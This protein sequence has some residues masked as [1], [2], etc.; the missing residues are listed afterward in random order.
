[1]SIQNNLGS[2]KPNVATKYKRG[3]KRLTTQQF[4]DKAQ[5]IHQNP[6]GSPKYDYSKTVYVNSH[7]KVT[8]ICAKHGEFEQTPANHLQGHGCRKCSLFKTTKQFIAEAQA[9]H[10]NEDDSPK[11]DY[12]KTEY[13]GC[14]KKVTIICPIHGEFEKVAENHLQGK[15]CPQCDEDNS[16]KKKTEQSIARAKQFIARAKTVHVNEDGT[17]KYDYSKIDYTAYHYHDKV[18]IICPIH[19]EFQQR[20]SSHLSN[21]GCPDC[22][23]SNAGR[24]KRNWRPFVEARKYVR[25]LGFK[26][27]EEYQAWSKSGDRPSDIPSNPYRIYKDQGW[28]SWSHFLRLK[29]AD[30]LYINTRPKL[31]SN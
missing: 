16:K 30:H 10:V 25:S 2:Q 1:M 3:V 28:I 26:S 5:A 31:T 14:D 19:G 21:H 13:T 4:I 29:R 22:G 6:D 20:A 17:P 8:I 23:K 9:L 27:I 24:L 7:T 18:T 15:G 11:Y 12:S